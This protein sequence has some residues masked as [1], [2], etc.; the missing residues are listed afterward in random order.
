MVP[1]QFQ[2]GHDEYQRR[3][4]RNEKEGEVMDLG[5]CGLDQLVK[6]C[7]NRKVLPIDLTTVF[8]CKSGTN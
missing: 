8:L 6:I 3:V 1:R 4:E 2:F 7:Y 5:V